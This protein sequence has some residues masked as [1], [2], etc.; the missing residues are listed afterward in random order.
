MPRLLE[1]ADLCSS[2]VSDTANRLRKIREKKSSAVPFSQR[3]H[4]GNLRQTIQGKGVI[5]KRVE[6]VGVYPLVRPRGVSAR[7]R[8]IQAKNLPPVRSVLLT[9][10]VYPGRPVQ[11]EDAAQTG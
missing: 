2:T 4:I 3:S 8:L 11:K 7:S 6:T 9:Q 10:L 1:V 5:H